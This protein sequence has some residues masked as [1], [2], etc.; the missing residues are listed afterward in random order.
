VQ[1]DASIGKLFMTKALRRSVDGEAGY[2]P[3]FPD[4]RKVLGKRRSGA[5][6]ATTRASEII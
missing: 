2:G 5:R 1:S 3:A 4:T 6:P